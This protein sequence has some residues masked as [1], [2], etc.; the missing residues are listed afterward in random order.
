PY[1]SLLA[2]WWRSGRVA[3]FVICLSC[4]H[5][6]REHR[7]AAGG[8]WSLLSRSSLPLYDEEARQAER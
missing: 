2:G 4:P 6:H 1:A 3:V 7:G 8:S 5:D